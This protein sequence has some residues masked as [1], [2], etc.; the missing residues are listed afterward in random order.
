MLFLPER[1]YNF[2]WRN[3]SIDPLRKFRSRIS[4]QKE[5]VEVQILW[6]S[7]WSHCFSYFTTY[8]C[9]LHKWW[10]GEIFSHGIGSEF[11]NK[12][13]RHGRLRTKCW[14]MGSVLMGAWWYVSVL[15]DLRIKSFYRAVML[16]NQW[17]SFWPALLICIS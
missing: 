15:H 13:P 7:T 11:A 2:C 16:N 17:E 5:S 9:N 4:K 12:S 3:S 8:G 1:W 14:G 10:L 6:Q